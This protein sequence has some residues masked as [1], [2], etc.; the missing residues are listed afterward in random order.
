MGN[1][2]DGRR[3]DCIAGLAGSRHQ[4]QVVK[5]L[6]HQMSAPDTAIT[7]DYLYTLTKLKMQLEHQPLPP[8]PERDTQQ[9]KIWQERM[10]EQE[11][12][13]TDLEDAL[14]EKAA[15]LVSVKQGRARAE[16]VDALLLR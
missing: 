13:F 16:T 14:F 6:E 1:L 15:A 7:G 3:F 8:Y 11:R 12:K 2:P 4:V 5:E 9:Q 10:Q